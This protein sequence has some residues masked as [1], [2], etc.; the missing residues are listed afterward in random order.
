MANT[1]SRGFTSMDDEK[2]AHEVSSDEAKNAGK[3]DGKAVR[4]DRAQMADIGR[5]GDRH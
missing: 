1:S 2:Q 5:E 4:Q 3:K